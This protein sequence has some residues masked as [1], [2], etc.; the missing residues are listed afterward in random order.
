MSSFPV[1]SALDARTQA[2]PILTAAQ[3][4]RVRA[5]SDLR[6]VK[7][8]EILFE[9][10]VTRVPFFVLLSGA[11]EIVQPILADE[12]SIAKHGPGEFTGEMTMISGQR[13]LVLGRV[14]ET[15]RIFGV[16]RRRTA[17]ADRAET[18]S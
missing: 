7:A 4:S 1:P 10:G 6:S 16:E 8:S 9:P 12:R 18:L 15:W 3:I 17:L 5:L 2:F 14:T 13:C 11:M